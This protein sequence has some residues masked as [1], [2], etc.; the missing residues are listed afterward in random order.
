[1]TER[2][3]QKAVTDSLSV[4]GWRWTHF[5]PA[6]TERGW[7]TPLSGARGYPDVTAVRADGVLFLE[8]KA[9]Q[10]R[11]TKEQS[12]WLAALGSAG[13]EVHVWRPSDWDFIEETLR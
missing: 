13:G 10:G 2:E 9:E 1:V 5:R 12:A 7:R 3:F 11:L 8:L 6:R 4:F